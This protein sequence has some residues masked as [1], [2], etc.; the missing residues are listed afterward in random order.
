MRE[1]FPYELRDPWVGGY[2]YEQAGEAGRSWATKLELTG[3]SEADML[4]HA[5]QALLLPTSQSGSYIERIRNAQL[6]ER[7]L[8]SEGDLAMIEL[9][10]KADEIAANEERAA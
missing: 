1:L 6:A 10:I 2:L 7:C 3:M 9:R 8:V 4:F 5:R